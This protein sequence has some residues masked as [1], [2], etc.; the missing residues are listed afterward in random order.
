MRSDGVNPVYV[1]EYFADRYCTYDVFRGHGVAGAMKPIKD[2]TAKGKTVLDI[3][4][5]ADW[6]KIKDT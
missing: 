5:G 6:K 3:I 1:R 4:T 2:W